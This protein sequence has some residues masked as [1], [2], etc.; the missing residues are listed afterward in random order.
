MY[1]A[2]RKIGLASLSTMSLV[3]RFISPRFSADI[4][5]ILHTI[6]GDLLNP[7]VC[8]R[9]GVAETGAATDN[10][11]YASTCRHQLTVTSRRPGMIDRHAGP[12]LGRTQTGTR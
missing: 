10:G 11:E 5:A 1:G 7:G 12:P 9:D 6:E 2:G 3:R 4:A 8:S